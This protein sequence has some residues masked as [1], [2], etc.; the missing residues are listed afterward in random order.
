MNL[1]ELWVWFWFMLGMLTYW[2]KRGYYLITGPNPV[3]NS[4]RQFAQRCWAPLLIRAFLDSMAFWILFT[5]GLADKALA[6]L[7]WNSYTWAIEFI[8]TAAPIA[9]IFGHTVDSVM[10]FAV[11][12]IP[13]INGILPQMPGPLP[14]QAPPTP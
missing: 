4:W 10:D 11:S 1:Q 9:A 7:G 6:Y 5:P 14:Q 13:W 3:A 8:T 2:L 12:K